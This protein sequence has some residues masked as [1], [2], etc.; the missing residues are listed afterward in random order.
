MENGDATLQQFSKMQPRTSTAPLCNVQVNMKKSDKFEIICSSLAIF[1]ILALFQSA[2]L[3][4]IA[5]VIVVR[6]FFKLKVENFN[7][8]VPS[9]V[10]R[11]FDFDNSPFLAGI[12][13]GISAGIFIILI[14]T[15]ITLLL[16]IFEGISGTHGIGDILGFIILP[17]MMIAGQPWSSKIPN[18]II[19]LVLGILAN[20]CLIGI[21]IGVIAKFTKNRNKETGHN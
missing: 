1:V 5:V 2:I 15:A 4:I 11:L 7:K 12:L 8:I 13:S 9:L 6:M 17:I 16:A 20:G 18:H 21:V 10:K 19:G 14:L 3:N